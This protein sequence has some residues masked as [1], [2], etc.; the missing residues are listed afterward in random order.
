MLPPLVSIRFQV[1]FHSPSGVLFAFPSRY[2]FTIGGKRY[3]ALGGGPPGF[4]QGFS[5]PVLLG[6]L[7]RSPIPFTYRAFT[8]C[9]RPFHAVRLG[10]GF[11]TPSQGLQPLHVRSHNPHA[12]TPARY[13]H[14]TSLGC[15]AFARRYLRN[16]YCFL[17]LWLLR[18]FSSPGALP[19]KFPLAGDAVLPAPGFPIRKSPDQCLF[20]APRS[21]SPLI[22]SF[23]GLLPQGIH[24]TLFVA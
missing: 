3:L 24:R 7:T 12:A 22:A 15:S 11:V 17:F 14:D 2:W 13:V 9:G 4:T 18:C 8:F 21:V 6:C 20:A 23:V 19:P 10:I 1:L 5:C 16:R